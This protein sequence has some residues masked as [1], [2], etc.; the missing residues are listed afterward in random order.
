MEML[1]LLLDTDR[2]RDVGVRGPGQRETAVA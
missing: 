1:R 2:V